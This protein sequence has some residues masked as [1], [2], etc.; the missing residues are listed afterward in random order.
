MVLSLLSFD[1]GDIGEPGFLH[2]YI[3]ITLYFSRLD[4]PP[5]P[6]L[7][8]AVLVPALEA[9]QVCTNMV[10]GTLS[11]FV[12]LFLCPIPELTLKVQGWLPG[13]EKVDSRC[14]QVGVGTLGDVLRDQSSLPTV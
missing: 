8:F 4:I 6:A 12:F 10:A 13:W 2:T 9:L 7:T 3:L 1:A 14:H 5:G 11:Q